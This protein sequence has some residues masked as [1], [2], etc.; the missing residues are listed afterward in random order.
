MPGKDRFPKKELARALRIELELVWPEF[1]AYG[2]LW[3]IVKHEGP[4]DQYKER[5]KA[6]HDWRDAMYWS[7]E[8]HLNHV[9]GKIKKMMMFLTCLNQ[10]ATTPLRIHI[11]G[12]K[13]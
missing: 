6:H 10:V 1:F 8:A 2:K 11:T 5:C 3:D 13:N 12:E 9:S 7:I 4:Y